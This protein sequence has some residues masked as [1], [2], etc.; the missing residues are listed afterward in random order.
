MDAKWLERVYGWRRMGPD[1]AW[2]IKDLQIEAKDQGWEITLD[3]IYASAHMDK[4][5]RPFSPDI[6]ILHKNQNV[7]RCQVDGRTYELAPWSVNQ[8]S[9]YGLVMT[10]FLTVAN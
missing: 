9:G 4:D 3:I 6:F 10:S 1:A 7:G 2:M 5:G 8:D